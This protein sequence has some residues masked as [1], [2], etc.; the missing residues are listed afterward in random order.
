MFS[1]KRSELNKISQTLVGLIV[2]KHT[3]N[4]FRFIKNMNCCKIFLV[5]I[6]SNQSYYIKKN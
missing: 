2:K 4:I 3:F 5:V 1:N 6:K